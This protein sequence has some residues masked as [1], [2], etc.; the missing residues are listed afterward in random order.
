MG[1]RRLNVPHTLTLLNIYTLLT[2]YLGYNLAPL[3][4]IYFLSEY[5]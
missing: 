2:S 4:W 5:Q 3:I 1:P